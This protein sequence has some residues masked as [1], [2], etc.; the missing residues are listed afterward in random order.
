MTHSRPVEFEVSN[1][2]PWNERVGVLVGLMMEENKR[3]M[4]AWIIRVCCKPKCFL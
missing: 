2:I 4:L 1:S 3:E